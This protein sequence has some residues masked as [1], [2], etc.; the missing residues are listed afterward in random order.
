MS[1][2]GFKLKE[3]TVVIYGP[4]N[5][6]VQALANVLQEHGADI[7]LLA[8]KASESHRFTTSLMEMRQ[9]HSHYGRAAGINCLIKNQSDAKEALS[10]AAELFGSVD[11]FID[12]DLNRSIDSQNLNSTELITT[13]A[14]TFFRGRG[15]GRNIFLTHDDE[16]LSFVKKTERVT[17]NKKLLEFV[18]KINSSLSTHQITSNIITLPISEEFLIEFYPKQNVQSSFDEIKNHWANAKLLNP[19]DVAQ[20]VSFIASAMST[21]LNGQVIRACYGLHR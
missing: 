12:A 13:E 6:L 20:L 10:K 2:S 8:E 5:G 16:L 19:V 18:R 7:A 21:S 11:V 3:K 17:S 1:E 4:I 14:L 15:R 9:V